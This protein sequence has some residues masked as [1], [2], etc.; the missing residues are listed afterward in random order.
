MCPLRGLLTIAP[1]SISQIRIVLSLDPVAMWY[2]FG[3]QQMDLTT[4]AC[5]VH[6]NGGACH[7]N[8]FPLCTL[9]ILVNHVLKVADKG[10]SEGR[11]G[12]AEMYVCRVLIE[13]VVWKVMTKRQMS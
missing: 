3:E 5:P 13:S 10:D 1:V 4:P 11:K 8:N 6:C 7:D 2:P 9:I 12:P